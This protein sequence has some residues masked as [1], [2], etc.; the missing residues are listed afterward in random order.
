MLSGQYGTVIDCVFDVMSGFTTT[1]LYLL[2]DLDHT[3]NGL[4]MW[5]FILTFAGGQ[6]IV[7]LALTFLFRGVPGTFQLY[8][9]EG[10]DEKLVPATSP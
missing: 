3:S 9:G 4:N 8:A 5:R 1:G 2:Q 6:G 10:K 7:V